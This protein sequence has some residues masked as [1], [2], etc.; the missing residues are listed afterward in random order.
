MS[1]GV[2][3][4]Q[5]RRLATVHGKSQNISGI[6]AAE[7]TRKKQVFCVDNVN[8]DVSVEK[9][10]NFITHMQ[11]SLVS[12][13]EVKTRRRFNEDMSNVNRRAFRVC[14][15]E[16]DR[17]R[18]LN[19][20][21]WPHSVRVSEWFSKRNSARPVGG[22]DKRIRVGNGELASNAPGAVAVV[23][24]PAL[25]QPSATVVHTPAQPNCDDIR[26]DNDDN[27]DTIIVTSEER[28][29]EVTDAIVHAE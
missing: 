6:S 24:Q 10:E 15:F 14:I 28:S 16:E 19:P 13:F 18:F 26:R 9:M 3:P 27:D 22:G 5:Q 29:M 2:R 23:R 8:P 11:I 20:E 1:A 17:D 4:T 7:I 12:C 25:E 21:V